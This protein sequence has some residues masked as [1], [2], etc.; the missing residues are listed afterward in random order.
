M[1]VYSMAVHDKFG[2]EG[3]VGVAIVR[4]NGNDW[5]IDSFLMS[6]R[7]IG[8][9]VETALL[10][11][12]VVD[13]RKAN[14]ARIL[15]EYISTKKNLPASDLY[16]RHGFGMPATNDG[17]TSWILNLDEQT[18]DIPEWIELTEA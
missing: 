14:V 16:E 15:G 8:R 2:D 11:K 17:V 3:V 4:K 10:A 6:C 7:V 13:A 5:W 9:S 18:I 1:A 12:I